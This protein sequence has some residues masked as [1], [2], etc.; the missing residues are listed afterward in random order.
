MGQQISLILIQT[1]EG[2]GIIKNHCKISANKNNIY[3][4]KHSDYSLGFMSGTKH[5]EGLL[6][7]C[8]YKGTR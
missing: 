3:L 8:C 4:F 6:F 2:R 5:P 1:Y 7:T